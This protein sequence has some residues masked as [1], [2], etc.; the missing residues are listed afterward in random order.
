VL[1]PAED[2]LLDLLF[3]WRLY[4]RYRVDP[5]L[6]IDAPPGRPAAV[7]PKIRQLSKDVFDEPFGPQELADAFDQLHEL[8]RFSDA[9]LDDG[10]A[11]LRRRAMAGR[12][13]ILSRYLE[14]PS[15]FARGQKLVPVTID[16]SEIAALTAV[17][18]ALRGAVSARGIVVEVNPSSNL[19][20]GDMLDLRNHPVLRLFPPEP[21]EPIPPVHIAVG[22]DDPV[23]FNTHLIREYTL[24]HDAAR[25][26]GYGERVVQQWLEAIRRTGMDARFTVSWRPS[27]A[28]RARRL[29]SALGHYAQIPSAELRRRARNS[30]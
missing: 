1:V 3:E 29:E 9:P 12:N 27:A 30:R 6:V 28:E 4:A 11:A 14:N 8:L 22:S 23:T 5:D 20:I 24:L 7:E 16:A 26:A 17:Q 13:G 18:N 25:A 19:L 21:T 10:L 2:R 15:V